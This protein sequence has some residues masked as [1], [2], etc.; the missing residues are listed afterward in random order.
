MR[1]CVCVCVSVCVA[2]CVC[3]CESACQQTAR[4]LPISVCGQ[5]HD[6]DVVGAWC[7]QP[8]THSAHTPTHTHTLTHIQT[9]AHTRSRAHTHTNTHTHLSASLY[10]F[11][12]CLPPARWLCVC[13]CT[14]VHVWAGACMCARTRV[15]VCT[16]SR[17]CLPGD[18][19]PNIRT[20]YARIMR[21]RVPTML[22]TNRCRLVCGCA[23][24]RACVRASVRA[25]ECACVRACVR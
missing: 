18:Q 19:P 11:P 5:L 10:R 8:H 3:V 12:P 22:V 17:A 15:S 6:R 9:H 1:V 7:L 16:G 21:L 20:R 2:V 14:R 25:C 13:V 4:A 24:V 23:C